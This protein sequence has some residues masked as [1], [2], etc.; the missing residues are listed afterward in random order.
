M[1]GRGGGGSARGYMLRG[2]EGDAVGAGDAARDV[3]WSAGNREHAHGHRLIKLRLHR[4][5]HIYICISAAVLTSVVI[6]V[7]R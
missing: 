6:S 7:S 2:G 1:P 4:T 3:W 5:A